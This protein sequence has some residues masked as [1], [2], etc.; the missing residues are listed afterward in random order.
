M[1]M[2]LLQYLRDWFCKRKYYGEFTITN[3]NIVIRSND[4]EQIDITDGQYFRVIGSALNDDVW[5]YPATLMTDETFNGAIW[6]LKIPLAIVRIE[7]E[8][9]QWQAK[10]GDS[11]L[12]PWQSESYSRGAYSRSKGSAADASMS[13]KTAFENRLAPWRKL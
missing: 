7:E 4:T 13:W 3:G 9:K 5:K 12:S 10:N 2:E 6:V 8:I 11:V 1:M